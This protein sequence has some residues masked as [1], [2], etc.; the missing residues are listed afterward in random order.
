MSEEKTSQPNLHLK[1]LQMGLQLAL[2]TANEKVVSTPVIS[3]VNEVFKRARQEGLSECD[4]SA[5]FETC[6]KK[7]RIDS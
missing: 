2:V 6:R 5:V 4:A 3:A 1:H 7:S